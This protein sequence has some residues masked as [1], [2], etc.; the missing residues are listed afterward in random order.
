MTKVGTM[1]QVDSPPPTLASREPGR[2][3]GSK[4]WVPRNTW[5]RVGAFTF[6]A[7]FVVGALCMVAGS[8]LLKGE[9]RAS[10]PSPLIGLMVSFFA[11]MVVLCVACCVF[12]Y[13]SRL[14]AGS[15]RH[16]SIRKQL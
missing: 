16:P 3:L 15:F 7:F 12:W 8:F 9:I 6:G 14:L 5:A 4:D 1:R 13:G 2:A 10:I 11:V